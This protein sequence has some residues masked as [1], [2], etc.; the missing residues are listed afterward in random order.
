MAFVDS[1]KT[2]VVGTEGRSEKFENLNMG[3]EIEKA[4]IILEESTALSSF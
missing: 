1:S 4:D 3:M 2:Q